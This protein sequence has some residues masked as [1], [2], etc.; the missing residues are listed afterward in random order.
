MKSRT[1]IGGEE[2]GSLVGE[3]VWVSMGGNLS[4][5]GEERE[6]EWRRGRKKIKVRSGNKTKTR[7]GKKRAKFPPSRKQEEGRGKN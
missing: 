7:R 3:E 6:Y 4:A 2:R 5:R 1:T